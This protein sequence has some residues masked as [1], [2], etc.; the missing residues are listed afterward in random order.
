M[1]KRW[2]Y[3][4][5]IVLVII[6]LGWVYTR[7]PIKNVKEGIHPQ[8]KADVAVILN[9]NTL[10]ADQKIKMIREINIQD[11]A[12]ADIINNNHIDNNKKVEKLTA[13]FL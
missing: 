6:V 5:I 11:Q 1:N 4:T 7:M 12:Y 8:R 3:I 10:S 13:L 2:V 9:D